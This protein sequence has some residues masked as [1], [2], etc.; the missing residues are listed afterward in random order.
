MLRVDNP[1]NWIP[2]VYI[3]SVVDAVVLVG[4]VVFGSSVV[5]IEY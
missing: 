4:A 1:K 3:P 2:F 5:P